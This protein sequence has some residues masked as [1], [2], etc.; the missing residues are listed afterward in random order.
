MTRRWA[1]LRPA[2]PALRYR[3]CRSCILIVILKRGKRT[4]GLHG[5]RSLFRGA[6]LQNTR[7]NGLSI[8]SKQPLHLPSGT[9]SFLAPSELFGSPRIIELMRIL[10]VTLMLALLPMRAWL[11]DA[12]AMQMVAGHAVTTES[13]ASEHSDTRS[14]AT[15]SVNSE[16]SHLPCHEADTGMHH[17]S[18]MLAYTD[19]SDHSDCGQCSVCQV[20]H[21]AAILLATDP[22]VISAQPALLMH[23]ATSLFASVPS[24][25]HLKPPIS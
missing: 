22:L 6:I 9:G 5:V 12:M 16:V 13:V 2:H 18:E 24:A 4:H 3:L 8:G 1:A 17:G 7:L 10:I 19:V 14:E 25:P 15:F 23:S 21:G 11:G 20:C